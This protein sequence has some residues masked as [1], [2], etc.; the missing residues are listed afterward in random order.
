MIGKA[1]ELAQ[2]IP[3]NS[4]MTTHINTT[5]VAPAEI[6]GEINAFAV[7]AYNFTSSSFVG[8]VASTNENIN[9]LGTMAHEHTDMTTSV[10]EEN[11]SSK[12]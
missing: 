4:P 2:T 6:A 1:E 7:D 9:D 8:N 5:M 10:E 3:G 12:S 11:K